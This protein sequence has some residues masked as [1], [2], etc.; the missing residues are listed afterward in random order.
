MTGDLKNHED[1]GSALQVPIIDDTV[2]ILVVHRGSHFRELEFFMK[3][4]GFCVER[5]YLC[6]EFLRPENALCVGHEALGGFGPVTAIS[7]PVSY[8]HLRAHETRHD[9]VCR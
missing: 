3:G 7:I 6:V 2:P 5:K 9:L 8:T 4:D 1:Y